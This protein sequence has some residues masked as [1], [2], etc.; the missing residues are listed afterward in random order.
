M[1]QTS[2]ATTE[3]NE[4]ETASAVPT[5]L[6]VTVKTRDRAKTADA[7]SADIRKPISGRPAPGIE[8]ATARRLP[9]AP[10]PNKRTRQSSYAGTAA[11]PKRRPNRGLPNSTSPEAKAPVIATE[12]TSAVGRDAATL[13]PSCAALYSD[14]TGYVVTLMLPGTIQRERVTKTAKA[15]VPMTA[16]SA[17]NSER[18]PRSPG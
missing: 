14:T 18:T 6:E 17:T 16:G 5:S 9:K 10:V 1:T 7:P 2:R 13:F 12:V 4:I 3:A 15:Y 11:V 8:G